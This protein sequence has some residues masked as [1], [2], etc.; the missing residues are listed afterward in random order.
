MYVTVPFCMSICLL[1]RHLLVQAGTQHQ[2]RVKF[3][4]AKPAELR[5][6]QHRA[7]ELCWTNLVRSRNEQR[8]KKEPCLSGIRL[9]IWF[10]LSMAS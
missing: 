1:S 8:G 6:K 3:W 5:V 4:A 10:D 9:P 2:R 7:S